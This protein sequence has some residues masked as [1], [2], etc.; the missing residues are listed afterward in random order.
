MKIRHLKLVTTNRANLRNQLHTINV[1]ATGMEEISADEDRRRLGQFTIPLSLSHPKNT[2]EQLMFVPTIDLFEK[3][4]HT[5]EMGRLGDVEKYSYC[6]TTL[7][8]K[9]MTFIPRK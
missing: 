2:M 9:R 5:C 1:G 6:L 7:R 4:T 8:E 3:V